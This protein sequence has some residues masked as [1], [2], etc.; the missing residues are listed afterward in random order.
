MCAYV[1]ACVQVCVFAFVHA[2]VPVSVLEC[3]SSCVR[4]CE[5][6][7]VC[8]CMLPILRECACVQDFVLSRVH[9]RLEKYT[10]TS[11]SWI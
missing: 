1:R 8:V 7:R 3:M 6:G 10:K 11:F 9:V 2:S 5:S 4:E